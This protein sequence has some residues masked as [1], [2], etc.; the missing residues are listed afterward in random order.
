MFCSV[1]DLIMV[2]ADGGLAPPPARAHAALRLG[3]QEGGPGL[4]QD[5]RLVTYTTGG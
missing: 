3:K 2:T 1:L 4:S 5:S